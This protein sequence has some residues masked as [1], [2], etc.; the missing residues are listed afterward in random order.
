MK[1]YYEKIPDYYEGDDY[2]V[3]TIRYRETDRLE[4]ESI[5]LSLGNDDL[6]RRRCPKKEVTT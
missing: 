6:Y 3:V 5:G 2:P 1:V 4:A